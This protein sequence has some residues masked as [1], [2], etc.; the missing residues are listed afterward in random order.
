MTWIRLSD[1]ESVNEE[2]IELVARTP[3]LHVLV[4]SSGR[5]L[6]VYDPLLRLACDRLTMGRL[7]RLISYFRRNPYKEK[8]KCPQKDSSSPN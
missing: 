4:L 1:T 2:G 8:V 3:A 6:R 5:N 7:E